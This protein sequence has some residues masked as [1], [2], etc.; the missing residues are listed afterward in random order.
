MNTTPRTK[1]NPS[2]F[3]CQVDAKEGPEIEVY[4]LSDASKLNTTGQLV[5]RRYSEAQALVTERHARFMGRRIPESFTAE[6]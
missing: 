4:D 6:G 2:K 5:G 1:L 3:T